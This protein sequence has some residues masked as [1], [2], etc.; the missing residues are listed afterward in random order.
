MDLGRAGNQLFTYCFAKG[1]AHAMG[2]ELQVP[3][4]W[5]GRKVFVNAIEPPCSSKLPQTE[6]DGYSSKPL[7]YFFGKKDIDLNVFAQHQCY[8]DFYTRKQAREW[9]KIKPE[10]DIGPQPLTFAGYSA[11]HLR[12]GDYI[13]D[14]Y[15]RVN[16]CQVSEESYLRAVERFKIPEPILYV[17]EGWRTPPVDKHGLDWFA[18][19]LL[20][21]NATYLLRANSTFSWWASV[22]GN[23]KTFSPIVGRR[24][25][26]NDVDF[27]D[28]N[29][30]TTAGK[31]KN[32]SDL[33]LKDQ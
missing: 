16:Y 1:Y 2:C 25:G 3:A 6:C 27:I 29:W 31:F 5:W 15:I 24:T 23:A 19:F 14:P 8:L 33:H 9:L 22:L 30:P 17:Y 7:G 26:P 20:L 4:D 10:F 28:G 12:L 11:A 21:K 18:D 32:Q 13:T